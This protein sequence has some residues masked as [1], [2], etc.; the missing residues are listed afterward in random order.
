MKFE[1]TI[2]LGTLL[3]LVGLVLA[4]LVG[5]IKL[6]GKVS[7]CMDFVREVREW[8]LTERLTSVETKMDALWDWFTTNLERRK[9]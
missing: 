9:L 1:W 2:T 5:Y 7:Q 6:N 4:V 8:K 3:H